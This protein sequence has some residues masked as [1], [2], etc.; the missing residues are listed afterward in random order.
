MLARKPLRSSRWNC[1]AVHHV[2]A[3][4]SRVIIRIVTC[5][6][7]ALDLHSQY[8]RAHL[9][10]SV[11]A[12]S[13][14][15]TGCGGRRIVLPGVHPE[16]EPALLSRVQPELPSSMWPKLLTMLPVR[17]M[18]A[19][20]GLGLLREQVMEETLR[21]VEEFP[22]Q[23]VMVRAPVIYLMHALSVHRKNICEGIAEQ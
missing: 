9:P 7:R 15:H 17:K 3:V 20:D 22:R 12:E 6:D 1:L 19:A 23:L 14:S 5:G 16:L 4:V 21:R 13:G 10:R 11:A 8:S 18:S 2:Q